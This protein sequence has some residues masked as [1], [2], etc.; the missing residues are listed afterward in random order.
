M[1]KPRGI[2]FLFLVLTPFLASCPAPQTYVVADEA[3]YNA[4]APDYRA[5]VETDN[6]LTDETKK[7]KLRTLKAWRRM[8]DNAKK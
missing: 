5:Y 3:I 6:A 4:I 2:P 7:T 1:L 8:I